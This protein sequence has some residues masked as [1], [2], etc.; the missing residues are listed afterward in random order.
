[1]S[2]ALEIDWDLLYK[3]ARGDGGERT[4]AMIRVGYLRVI[5]TGDGLR[6][7]AQEGFAVDELPPRCRVCGCTDD[8]CSACVERTGDACY[9]VEPDLCS[10]CW[11]GI[12]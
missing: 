8:N 5:V 9:W 10:A 6:A 12:R 1:M 2:G 7:L 3:L 11:M 4:G